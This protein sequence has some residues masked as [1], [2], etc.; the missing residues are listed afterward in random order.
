MQ[1]GAGAEF[2]PAHAGPLHPLLDQVFGATFDGTACHRQSPLAENWILHPK[3]VG[4]EIAAFA[5]QRPENRVYFF[6]E[7]VGVKCIEPAV[8]E[9]RTNA[10]KA[11]VRR[12]TDEQGIPV[13]S[14][15]RGTRKKELVA[16]YYRRLKG[17]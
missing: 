3:C 13:L 10:Y 12:I 5:L 9:Q 6:H 1:D 4:R 14:A 15:T 2:A 7:V 16:P 11:W 8:L 17:A